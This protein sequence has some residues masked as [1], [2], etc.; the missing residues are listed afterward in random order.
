MYVQSENIITAYAKVNL[1]L[2]VLNLREDGYHNIFSVMAHIE[3]NDLLK[4]DKFVIKEFSGIEINI[5]PTEGSF[6]N[7]IEEL[8]VEENLIFKAA[9]ELSV[10]LNKTFQANFSICKNIP[11]GAGLGGGSADAAAAL[12]LLYKAMDIPFLDIMD[13][14]AN[15]GADAPFALCE[16]AAICEGIGEKITQLAVTLPHFVLLINNGD[17][18]DTRWAYKTLNRS[19]EF[20]IDDDYII[21]KK[22]K[23]QKAFNAKKWNDFFDLCTNDFEENVFNKY[24]KIA[25][26]KEELIKN[27]ADFSI[28]TGSGSTMIGLFSD[29]DRANIVFEKMRNTNKWVYLTKFV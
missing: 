6:S 28:M 29:E 4:L 19:S 27:G 14:A 17:H 12:T 8:P 1:N 2:E 13:L 7:I 22:E 3:L 16:G 9:Q 11:A 5:K 26:A 20:N 23:I 15:I 18:I 25:F 21:Q 10:K 24:P